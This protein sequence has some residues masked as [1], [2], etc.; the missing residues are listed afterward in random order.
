MIGAAA[1]LAGTSGL[2]HAQ[3]VLVPPTPQ[4]GSSNPVAAEPLVPRPATKPCIVPLCQDLRFTDFTLKP[5]TDSPQS[6]CP[7]QE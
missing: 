3:V 7:G 2:L 5:F 4:I 1:L 6:A